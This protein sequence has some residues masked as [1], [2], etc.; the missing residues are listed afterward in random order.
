MGEPMDNLD[1]QRCIEH[2]VEDGA[3]AVNRQQT[4]MVNWLF[5]VNIGGIGGLLTYVAAKGPNKLLLV[6]LLFFSLGLVSILLHGTIMFY[7]ML[8]T[9]RHLQNA[10]KQ[11]G[12]DKDLSLF[13]SRLNEHPDYNRWAERLAWISGI[14]AI[15]G[16]IHSAIGIW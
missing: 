3:K 8:G 14:A 16:G 5:A 4:L 13:I 9:Y 15:L 12:V 6:G 7:W 1:A 2:V 11:L 10:I